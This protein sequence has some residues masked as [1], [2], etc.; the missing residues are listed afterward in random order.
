MA[1]FRSTFF[2]ISPEP[3]PSVPLPPPA[4]PLPLALDPA[5]PHAARRSRRTYAIP[6]RHV[7]AIFCAALTGDRAEIGL[8]E[9][10]EHPRATTSRNGTLPFSPV[11]PVLSDATSTARPS[12]IANCSREPNSIPNTARR[13]RWFRASI[14]S[15]RF[16]SPPLSPRHYVRSSKSKNTR[17]NR[18]VG[19]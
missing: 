8:R 5:T 16:R 18:D 10:L 2:F 13:A 6:R 19:R 14:Y 15:L 12:P 4:D 17:K 7:S 11:S 1:L 9:R 3:F